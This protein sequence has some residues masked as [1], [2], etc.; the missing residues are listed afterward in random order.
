[1]FNRAQVI[2]VQ[3]VGGKMLTI[4]N[5]HLPSSSKRPLKDSDKV[6]ALRVLTGVVAPSHDAYGIICGDINE[7]NAANMPDRLRL[8]E[9]G[10]G[11]WRHWQTMKQGEGDH[12]IFHS[13]LERRPSMIDS[14]WKEVYLSPHYCTGGAFVPS[15]VGTDSFVELTLRDIA[16]P[17]LNS[18]LNRRGKKVVALE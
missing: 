12:I 13:T 1:M 8:A 14:R 9:G 16:G 7:K 10:A 4:A 2:T 15:E 5:V 18:V 3:M 17:A 6:H 11:Q